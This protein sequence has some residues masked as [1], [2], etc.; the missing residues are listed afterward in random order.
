MADPKNG[1]R[2]NSEEGNKRWPLIPKHNVYWVYILAFIV[3]FSLQFIDITQPKEITWLAFNKE[4]L[5]EGDVDRVEV[6]NKELAEVYIKKESLGKG[7]YKDIPR[8]GTDP[9]PHFTF[10]IGSVETFEQKMQ[11]AQKKLKVDPVG[12]TYISRRNWF[13]EA[14]G[15]LL[16]LGFMIVIWVLI[17]RR[18][19][20]KGSAG[21]I[22][23]AFNFGKSKALLFD[24]ENGNAI[25]FDDVAGLEEAK[26]EV[27]EVV[28]FLK[29]PEEYTKL[30]AK[31]PKGVILVGPPGTGKTL[32]AKAVAT[33]AGVPVFTIAGSDFVEMFV[34]VGASRVR[35]LFKQAKQKA[36]C[37]I[38]IDEID[39]IGRARGKAHAFGG[40]DERE[41]TLN[42][43]LSE[44]DGF[45]TNTGVIVLA[46]TNRA[47]ILDHALLRPGRFDRHIYLE[48]PN[49]VER[50]AI[51]K[52]HLKPLTITKDLD[53]DFLAA[54]TPGFSGADIA[55]VCNEA[56]LIAAREKK[57]EIKR[58][59]FTAAID[60]IVAGLERK[61]KIISPAEKKII[62]IHEA[63][64]AV[65]SWMLKHTAPLIKVTIIP[66]GKSLGSAW[67]LPEERQINTKAQF[68]DEMCAALGGRV[69][70]DLIFNEISSGALDDLEKI[71]KQAYAMVAIYGLNDKVGSIS[72]YDSTGRQDSAFQKPYSEDTS[73]MID[74]EVRKLVNHAYVTTKKLLSEN[75]KKLEELASLL[76][77][78]EI[79]FKKDLEKILGKRTSRGQTE[80]TINKITDNQE[81]LSPIDLGSTQRP[82]K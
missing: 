21:G 38:F 10:T 26:A 18:L 33:E 23:S 69:A 7:T 16:P 4:M 55:N 3:L 31:I 24:R 45:G 29:S 49:M 44:M 2:I 11:D 68:F 42:Q 54:Q 57:K 65:V 40:N 37:I 34:G 51:F 76:L 13:G 71:T 32:M 62:S 50:R 80:K 17:M 36:P 8:A 41:S 56:A 61:S 39:S 5:A 64:H 25:T 70:E 9:G 66:R 72:Y 73:K 79:V 6:V 59:D 75:R 60:R 47:D 82:Q 27:K 58:S 46:A 48:L 1:N 20:G 81:F 30:G 77:E 74:E 67:S 78:K 15:W 22:G 14:L 19:S 43:L 63:G 28:D 35:D 53:V 52:V 12:I